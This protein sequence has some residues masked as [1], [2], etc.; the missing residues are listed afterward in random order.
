M[1]DAVRLYEGLGFIRVPEN[2][3]VPLEDGILVKAYRLPF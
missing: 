1:K 3:F 2:D